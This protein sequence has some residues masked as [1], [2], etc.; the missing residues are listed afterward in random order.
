MYVYSLRY[1]RLSIKV[2]SPWAPEPS[3]NAAFTGSMFVSHCVHGPRGHP[4]ELPFTDHRVWL[5]W[6]F[7][8]KIK[9]QFFFPFCST[10]TTALWFLINVPFLLAGGFAPGSESCAFKTHTCPAAGICYFPLFLLPLSPAP[11]AEFSLPWQA[12]NM[13]KD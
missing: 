2:E 13:W 7:S 3:D 8:L 4:V 6:F 12:D 9:L 11:G 10:K 1:S 5:Q